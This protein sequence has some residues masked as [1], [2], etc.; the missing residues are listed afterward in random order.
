MTSTV[1]ED[2]KNIVPIGR[3]I[4][5]GRDGWGLLRKDGLEGSVSADVMGRYWI[6]VSGSAYLWDYSN[7]PYVNTGNIE[8]DARATAWFLFDNIAAAGFCEFPGIVFFARGDRFARFVDYK[9]DFRTEGIRKIYRTPLR[10]FGV[11]NYLKNIL[12]MWVTVRADTNT[13]I[14]LVYISEQYP[15]GEVETEDVNA[16]SFTWDRSTWDRFSWSVYHFA[17]TFRRKVKRKKVQRF[18][19]EFRNSEIGNDLSIAEIK[20]DYA[21]AKQIKEGG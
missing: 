11:I 17:V 12:K 5:E 20:F 14:E 19:V 16:Y 9:A 18:A 2:E 15:N 4:D 10:D 1:I 21:I 13:K 7:Y 6:C 3:N 8:A